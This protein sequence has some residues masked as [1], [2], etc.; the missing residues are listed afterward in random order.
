MSLALSPAGRDKE[1]GMTTVNITKMA[2]P[3]NDRRAQFLRA[4]NALAA[5]AAHLCAN[6]CHTQHSP[7]CKKAREELCWMEETLLEWEL[8]E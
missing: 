8:G 2:I 4:Y 7:A 6:E 5:T 1:G 3:V